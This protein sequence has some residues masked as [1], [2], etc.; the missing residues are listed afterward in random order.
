MWMDNW[1]NGNSLR[2]MIEGPLRQEEQNLR[3]SDL[4][5]DQEWKWELFSFDLPQS[6]KE[7][8]KAIPIQL[9]G[10][11]RDTVLWKF[12][13]NGEF[14]TSSAYRLAIQG[15]EAV[16]Q[17]HGQWIW[18]LDILPRITNFLWLCL[19]GSI[20]VREVLAERG[21]ICE[22]VCPI[23]REQDE[24][25]IHLFHECKF[26][27]DVWRKLV[28][29]PSHVSSFANNFEIWLKNNCLSEVR[30]LGSIPWCFL[31]L[32]AVWNLWKNRN[33]VVF[34]N[35][36]PNLTLDKICLSQ[37]KEYYYCVSKA[38]QV[39]SKAVIL[40]KWSKPIPGW[41]KLNTDG[42]SLGN[43]G[44]AGGGGLIRNSE[45]G[46]IKGFSRAIGYTT[47]VMVE[48]WALRDGLTLANQ[49]GIGYLEVELDAKDIVE[50]LN[51]ADNSKFFFLLCF[52]TADL[53]WQI[54]HRFR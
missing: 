33:R 22:K 35:S 46:W 20:P 15:E 17:F 23:C 52:L 26:A 18:K 2:S 36:I 48:L 29:P 24:S 44:K 27:C 37:A 4:W 25:I 42:A 50:M 51:K 41:H 12:S 9:H 13:K 43:L 1:V 7:K 49:L 21:I 10:N 38:K 8:I 28:V 14:T 6:I 31:F 53:S 16:T 47:S 32:F 19:H 5:C 45:G 11:G 30:H 54:S 40:V 39:V 3:I 34:E